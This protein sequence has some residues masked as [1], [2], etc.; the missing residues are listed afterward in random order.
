MRIGCHA[1]AL[2]VAALM[3]TA[4]GFSAQ[5]QDAP[6][7][8]RDVETKYVFGFTEGSGIGLVVSKQLVELMGGEI[9]VE[10]TVWTG[11]L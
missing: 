1:R 6:A 3:F 10:S 7:V 9:G 2:A 8:W 11:S 4:N 5:A